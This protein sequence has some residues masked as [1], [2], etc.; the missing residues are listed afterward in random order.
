MGSRVATLLLILNI[1]GVITIDLAFNLFIA[2]IVIDVVR[3]MIV[4]AC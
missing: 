4:E 3:H 1:F 2:Y